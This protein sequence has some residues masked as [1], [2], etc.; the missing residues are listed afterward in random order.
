MNATG[1]RHHKHPT[2]MIATALIALAILPYV[3]G[4][5]IRIEFNGALKVLSRGRWNE[6]VSQLTSITRVEPKRIVARTNLAIALAGR[7]AFHQAIAELRKVLQIA[8]DYAPA[9]QALEQIES[10]KGP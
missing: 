5:V 2:A 8:P 3:S 6:T 4:N 1:V 9:R 7:G 10:Q